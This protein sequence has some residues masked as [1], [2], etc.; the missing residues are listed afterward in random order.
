MAKNFVC[1]TTEPIVQ[2]KAGK[3]RGFILDGT[4]TFYG[5][6]YAD[7]KRFQ[8]PTPP[9]PWEGVKDALGYGYVCPMLSQ[10][11]PGSGELK[12]PHRYW[13]MDE[14]C[15][16]LNVWTQTLNPKAKKPVMVWLHGGGFA[17]GSSIEQQA[18]DGDNMTS[19]CCRFPRDRKR[20]PPADI[21]APHPKTP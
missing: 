15:Q 20:P 14:N 18:Y 9:E 3:L 12:V 17:A 19:S 1:T 7:A 6:K 13:P 21:P 16:Y 2:T 4:Y 10:D 8:Q 5:I 11:K